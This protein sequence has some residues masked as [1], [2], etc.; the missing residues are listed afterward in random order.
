MGYFNEESLLKFNEMCSDGVNF[1]EGDSYDFARC[2]MPDGEIYG[3]KGQCKQGKPIKDKEKTE[4]SKES[5]KRKRDLAK[6][7]EMYR[8]KTGKDLSPKQLVAVANRIGVPIPAGKSAED[9]L[10]Q[11][12]PKGEKVHTPVRSA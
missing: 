3:T 5:K 4:E 6:L 9:V 8:A 7:T 1:A 11:L 2:I 12:L 10:Q